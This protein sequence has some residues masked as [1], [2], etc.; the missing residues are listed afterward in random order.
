[1]AK[2]SSAWSHV[3]FS[4]A[5]GFSLTEAMISV[6][7]IGLLALFV[8]NDLRT[9]Q[10]REQLITA[11]RVL[12]ADIRSLQS[13][14]LSAQNIKT[15]ASLGKN[16]ACEL[17]DAA[18]DVPNTCAPLP[19]FSFGG[20][21]IPGTS[22]YTFFAEVDA[23]NKDFEETPGAGETFL[24][25]DLVAAGGPNVVIDQLLGAGSYTEINV[26][27]ER[28]NGAMHLNPCSVCMNPLTLTI[29]LRHTQTGDTK[30]V[31]LNAVTGR[32]SIE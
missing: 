12:A 22:S 26:V 32:V 10:K 21:F 13:R 15:C 29:R 20:H 16:I 2:R 24:T 8:V 7:I 19:P 27:F 5:S 25:R 11:A 6:A 23:S 30:D 9:S 17:S 14:A 28:Q 31:S 4:K 3:A 18:C 1:M